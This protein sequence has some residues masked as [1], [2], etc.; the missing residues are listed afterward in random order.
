MRV[1]SSAKFDGERYSSKFFLSAFFSCLYFLLLF[2]INYMERANL[3][4]ENWKVGE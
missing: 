4:V 1:E 2:I 3:M